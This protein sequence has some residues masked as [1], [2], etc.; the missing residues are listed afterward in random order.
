MTR[1]GLLVCIA[2]QGFWPLQGRWSLPALRLTGRSGSLKTRF[3]LSCLYGCAGPP[4]SAGQ[5]VTASAR[6]TGCSGS[7]MTRFRL[8]CLYGCAGP[9]ASA[10]PLVMPAPRLTGRSGSLMTRLRLLACMAVQGFW[11]LQGRWS[12]PAPVALAVQAH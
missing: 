10:R 2:V 3:R 1:F 6:R 5:L 8:A 4:A 12:L 7:Q 9:P 11:P